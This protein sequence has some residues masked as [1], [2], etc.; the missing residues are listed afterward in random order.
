MHN[1]TI[2]DIIRA[3]N[4]KGHKVFENDTR[5]FNINYGA[6]RDPERTGTWNDQFFC[7][8]KYKG[9]WTLLQ[10]VGTTDPGMYYH[11]NLLNEKGVAI[12][13]EGQHEKAF[14]LG[15]HQN[16]YTALVQARPIKVYRDQNLD[17]IMNLD[18]STLDEGWH[19]I[20]HHRSL[21]DAEASKVGKFSAGCQ[22]RL[23]PDEHDLFMNLFAHVEKEWGSNG[24]TYTL[25]NI[26]DF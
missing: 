24:Q 20:H 2:Q 22:V 1:L 5:P 23:N 26:A 8:W 7:F 6:V 17:G 18:A 4:R 11:Q 9:L 13:P 15:K 21:S 10:H 12:L 16:R 25:M 3:M 14:K 19:G